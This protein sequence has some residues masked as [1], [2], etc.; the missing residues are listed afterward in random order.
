MGAKIIWSPGAKKSLE[1][2]VSFLESKWEKK[3]IENLFSEL[4]D[5]LKHISLNPEMFPLI[6]TSKNI[7]K[8][9]IERKTLLLY[10]IKSKN[11][12]EL[13]ILVDSR[14]NPKKYKI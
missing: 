3:I 1:E 9:V 10:R 2:L 13:V 5:S 6:S 11:I 12:I 7:R 8:C 4:N 14:C